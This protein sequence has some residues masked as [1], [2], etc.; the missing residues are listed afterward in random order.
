[1]AENSVYVVSAPRLSLY[2]T[3]ECVALAT[4]LERGRLLEAWSVDDENVERNGSENSGSKSLLFI[5]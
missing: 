2:D 1:M 3:A 5:L 4:D